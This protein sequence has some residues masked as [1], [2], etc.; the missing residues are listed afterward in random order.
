MIMFFISLNRYSFNFSDVRVIYYAS[1]LA[2][3]ALS[4]TLTVL[5][6]LSNKKTF[7]LSQKLVYLFLTFFYPI[8]FSL[9]FLGSDLLSVFVIFCI[10]ILFCIVLFNMVPFVYPVIGALFI[11]FV[12]ISPLGENIR[13][14]QMA[15]MITFCVI[16]ILLGFAKR[17]IAVTDF[18]QKDEI[19]QLNKALTKQSFELEAQQ[20]QLQQTNDR[21]AEQTEELERQQ[22]ELLYHKQNL[23]SE[24]M[25]QTEEIRKNN[26]KLILLQDNMIIGL[27]NLIE[28]RD[29]DTGGHIKRTGL[30]V[31]LL[32]RR[33]MEK[34]LFA[35]VLTDSYIELLVKAAP[36]HDIGK[37]IV[38][39]AVLKKPGRLTDDEFAVMKTHASE[40]GRIV[41]E[42]I[43]DTEDDVYVQLAC[44]IASF[45]HERYD[46]TGYPNGIAG[47][48]IPLCARIMAIADVFDAL[49]S[50]RC[51]KTP[52]TADQ[53]FDILIEGAG[54]HFDRTLIELFTA[55][56]AEV[57]AIL[58]STQ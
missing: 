45:H 20:Q 32:A 11:V 35:S 25:R 5:L 44:D 26:E 42:V 28:N 51:Y 8:T 52:F 3:S 2:A 15:N 21:L 19:A 43:C 38:P 9:T 18:K 14:N 34:G 58:E 40:G 4:L 46:G 36:L 57:I 49:V 41:K 55:N 48:H 56:K 47:E 6:S 29:G 33:A 17:Y 30:Y 12:M 50:P 39:D 24:V 7:E 1:M 54:T 53:A 22:A 37:I 23:E 16:S 31:E 27:S 10:E 13:Q